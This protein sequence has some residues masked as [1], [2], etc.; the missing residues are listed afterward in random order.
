MTAAQAVSL[1][2]E[3]RP[4]TALPVHYEGWRHFQ[5]GRRSIEAELAKAPDGIRDRFRWLP[6]GT[7]LDITV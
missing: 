5:E 3:L 6:M 1:C 2:G 4:R 7:P